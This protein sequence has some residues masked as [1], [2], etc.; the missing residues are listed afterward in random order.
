[1]N[2]RLTQALAPPLLTAR[3]KCERETKTLLAPSVMHP[4]GEGSATCPW[5][6]SFQIQLTVT[7]S[8]HLFSRAEQMM[9]PPR[10]QPGLPQARLTGPTVYIIKM[11]FTI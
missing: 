4:V 9:P 6:F 2:H 8:Y 1:M 3:E 10:S 11:L 5:L 7:A